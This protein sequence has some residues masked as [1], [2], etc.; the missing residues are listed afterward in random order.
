MLY[1]TFILK[2]NVYLNVYVM[3]EY[4]D[5][6]RAEGKEEGREEGILEGAI[7]G[8]IETLVELNSPETRIIDKIME[9]FD[10]T[11]KVAREYISQY[12]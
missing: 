3:K 8:T 6:A 11:E 2:D 9:K 7:K 4:E 10:L 12:A 1:A 5:I